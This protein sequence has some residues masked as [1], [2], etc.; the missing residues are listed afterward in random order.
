MR[1]SNLR[2]KPGMLTH[3][4]MG[5]LQVIDVAVSQIQHNGDLALSHALWEFTQTVLES[6]EVEETTRRDVIEKLSFLS[7]QVLTTHRQK[8]QSIAGT[9]LVDLGRTASGVPVLA[10]VWKTLEPLL[11]QAIS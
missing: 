3:V 9:V 6:R 5:N 11:Q 10:P 1:F 2:V 7:D 4:D 8:Q